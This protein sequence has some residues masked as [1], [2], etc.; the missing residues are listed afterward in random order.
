MSELLTEE[1]AAQ[2]L[3]VSK[4]WLRQQRYAGTGPRFHRLGDKMIRYSLKDVLQWAETPGQKETSDSDLA[5]E[6]PR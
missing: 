3:K 4:S 1:E 5:N 6:K 2:L